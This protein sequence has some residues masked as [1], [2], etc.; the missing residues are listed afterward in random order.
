MDNDENN[1]WSYIEDPNGCDCNPLSNWEL[2]NALGMDPDDFPEYGGG[3]TGGE[4]GA[5]IDFEI[6][7]DKDVADVLNRD[8]E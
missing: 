7:E 1:D 4:G 5:G 6:A 8:L 2:A 3:S